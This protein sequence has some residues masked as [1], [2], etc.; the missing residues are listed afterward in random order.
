MAVIRKKEGDGVFCSVAAQLQK[1]IDGYQNALRMG[2]QGCH[3]SGDR[4]IAGAILSVASAGAKMGGVLTQ[5][6]IHKLYTTLFNQIKL[7]GALGETKQQLVEEYVD[8]L[9]RMSKSFQK[10]HSLKLINLR[11]GIGR[12]CE[13]IM[14][15]I[16]AKRTSEYPGLSKKASFGLMD[17]LDIF[18]GNTGTTNK[19]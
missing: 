4:K 7:Q 17:C 15:E 1:Q 10:G 14:Q 19:V 5:E 16:L 12:I 13:P 8:C 6:Q 11:Q 18:R 9:L 2:I 3:A